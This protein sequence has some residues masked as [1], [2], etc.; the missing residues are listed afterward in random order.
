MIYFFISVYQ[1]KKNK[2]KKCEKET[3]N[4]ISGI[5]YVHNFAESDNKM[6][7]RKDNYFCGYNQLT[8]FTFIVI[9]FTKIFK[10]IIYAIMLIR[11]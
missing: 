2:C 1:N 4:L 11:N 5:F 3:K 10:Q 6:K 8:P 7:S 9:Y